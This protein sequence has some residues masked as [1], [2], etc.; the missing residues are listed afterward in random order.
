VRIQ[1][2]FRLSRQHF[3][4]HARALIEQDDVAVGAQR[5]EHG[6]QASGAGTNAGEARTAGQ[7]YERHTVRGAGQPHEPQLQRRPAGLGVANGS[8][9]SPLFRGAGAEGDGDQ[10]YAR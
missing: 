4:G 8:A 2:G 1:I 9:Q 10:G 5:V 7:E 6:K 3:I